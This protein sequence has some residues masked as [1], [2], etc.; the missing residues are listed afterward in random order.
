MF[1]SVPSSDNFWNYNGNR[2]QQFPLSSLLIDYSLGLTTWINQ[3]TRCRKVAE[4]SA[5]KCVTNIQET[6]KVHFNVTC[7]YMRPKVRYFS[8]KSAE[9][10]RTRRSSLPCLFPGW[11]LVSLSYVIDVLLSCFLQIWRTITLAKRNSASSPSLV[12]VCA[13]ERMGLLKGDTPMQMRINT[14]FFV[15][16]RKM[17]CKKSV[18]WLYSKET[19]TPY[20][21]INF[22][23]SHT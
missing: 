18:W 2:P 7:K 22:N 9:K 11:Q 5:V 4:Y 23:Y 8:V 15:F 3:F 1:F 21:K 10:R 6:G 19:Y 13:A 17:F 16:S 20:T 12:K 14:F